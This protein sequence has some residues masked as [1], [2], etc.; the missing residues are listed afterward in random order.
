[1]ENGGL[2]LLFFFFWTTSITKT[3]NRGR[4]FMFSVSVIIIATVSISSH[5]TS[6]TGVDQVFMKVFPFA[7]VDKCIFRRPF[8]L[9]F[10]PWS[11]RA[12]TKP[13]KILHYTWHKPIDQLVVVYSV[14]SFFPNTFHYCFW[15]SLF[16]VW[17]SCFPL[18][19]SWLGLVMI[20]GISFPHIR[21]L[22]MCERRREITNWTKIH[23]LHTLIMY[24]T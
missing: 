15:H 9:K 23:N 14:G 11:V 22:K 21:S 16:S 1:M 17:H 20:H 13:H 6:R 24:S 7:R 5:S 4:L 18:F 3:K 19:C 8:H 12:H 10:F 2:L